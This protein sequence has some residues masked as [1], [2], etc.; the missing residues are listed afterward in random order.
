MKRSYPRP[1]GRKPGVKRTYC[2]TRDLLPRW[3]PHCQQAPQMTQFM[4]TL[5]PPPQ[6]VLWPD[7]SNV[8][9]VFEY[10]FPPTP[11]GGVAREM[12]IG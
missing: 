3:L 12:D 1:S 5:T 4:T 6:L 9:S 2:V 7:P 10:P 8:I 11:S